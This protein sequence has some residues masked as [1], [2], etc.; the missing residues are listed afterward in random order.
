M[1]LERTVWSGTGAAVLSPALSVTLTLT[2]SVTLTFTLATSACAPPTVDSSR[3]NTAND[4]ELRNRLTM[5]QVRRGVG[6]V[7]PYARACGH[8]HRVVGTYRVRVVMSGAQGRPIQVTIKST[9][10]HRPTEACLRRAFLMMRT[11]RFRSRTQ[12]FIFPMIY[13]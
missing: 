4:G 12:S 7:L 5:G 10:G 2:L 11:V 6:A 1:K 3:M 9:S 8:R 13:R